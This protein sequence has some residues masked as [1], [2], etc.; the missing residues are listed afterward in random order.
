MYDNVRRYIFDSSR[1]TAICATEISFLAL[2]LVKIK[3]RVSGHKK[4]LF[5]NPFGFANSL[6]LLLTLYYFPIALIS[7][8]WRASLNCCQS[9]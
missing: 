1:Y 6:V 8:P 7:M 9:K 5:A 3:I 2:S 4:K